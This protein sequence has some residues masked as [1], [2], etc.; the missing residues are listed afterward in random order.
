MRRK[1]CQ[2]LNPLAVCTDTPAME[3]TA[4]G[5]ALGVA[6]L[7]GAG[8]APAIGPAQAGVNSPTMHASARSHV[9]PRVHRTVRVPDGSRRLHVGIRLHRSRHAV[10]V[11]T[12]AGGGERLARRQVTR[13][14]PR[15]IHVPLRGSGPQRTRVVLRS[16][17]PGPRL[18]FL[19]FSG[20]SDATGS[21]APRQS[22][23]T[24]A[25]TPPREAL[26]QHSGDLTID[27]DGT[28]IDGWDIRG[29]VQIR[30]ANVTIRN[31]IIRGG[32][33]PREGSTALLRVVDS[34]ATGFHLVDTRL[35]P[36]TPSVRIDGVMVSRPSIFER[37]ELTGT[38]DGI[39][40]FGDD[41]SV[42][43]S[44]IHDMVH[45]PSDPAHGG[46]ASHDDIIQ[47]QQ[48]RGIQITG[49][50][51][52]GAYNAAIQITQDLGPTTDLTIARNRIDGG[53]CS[54]NF[55]SNGAFQTGIRVNDNLFG[56]R[57]RVA[58]CAIIH[59][60][61]HSDLHPIGN[62]WAAG[63]AAGVLRGA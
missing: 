36:A 7:I 62:R 54:I 35:V 12:P 28:V 42:R 29:F 1:G 51:L 20:P 50:N 57:Q 55:K 10:L 25:T 40:I 13:R 60:V 4:A 14:S 3:I 58:G 41:I 61:G 46:G 39:K 63:G 22:T 59:A 17:E 43:D 45:Y 15:T 52:H 6:A 56:N 9:H 47:V 53:G 48:G 2:G 5:V 23:E 37:L 19:R 33:P 32:A 24:G 21:S 34:Q 8:I 49:N 11:V 38:A 31:S 27:R 18:R 30:A 44:H 16:A 26:R